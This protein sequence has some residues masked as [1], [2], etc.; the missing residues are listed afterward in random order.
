LL[1]VLIHFRSDPR[2]CAEKGSELREGPRGGM[3][4]FGCLVPPAGALVRGCDAPGAEIPP[5]Q[6]FGSVHIGFGS[7]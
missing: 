6:Q 5:R 2:G 4:E 7:L 3:Q 1:K